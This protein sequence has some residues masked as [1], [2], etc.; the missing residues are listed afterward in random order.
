[1]KGS[2]CLLIPKLA[3]LC[4]TP[5]LLLT[6]CM[7]TSENASLTTLGLTHGTVGPSTTKIDGEQ[8][9]KIGAQVV[10][11]AGK[12]EKALTLGG[13]ASSLVDKVNDI[14][15]A[16][17]EAKSDAS[18]AR[19]VATE[20]KTDAASAESEADRLI[21]ELAITKTELEAAKAKLATFD[22]DTRDKLRKLTEDQIREIAELKNDRAKFDQKL[23]EVL[24]NAK[25]TPEQIKDFLEQTKGMSTQEIVAIL[26]AAAGAA[27]VGGALG[28]TGKSRAQ[29]DIDALKERVS[30][31]DHTAMK[32]PN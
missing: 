20:A 25:L 18:R 7:T 17:S 2:A 3:L 22:A 12:A 19:D 11:L 16:A 13:Q 32:K 23:E 30:D 5:C 14:A 6:G 8:I 1:M 4:L 29:P 10:E 15:I 26:A 28:R 21:T 9:A 31:L 24:K 27:G